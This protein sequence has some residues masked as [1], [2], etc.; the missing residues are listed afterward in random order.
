MKDLHAQGLHVST[1]ENY[2]QV[3]VRG[4]GPNARLIEVFAETENGLPYTMVS[5]IKGR[6]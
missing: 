3:L 5:P 4:F 6:R 2:A 1:A